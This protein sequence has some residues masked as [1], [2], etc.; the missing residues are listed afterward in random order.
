VACETV[1]RTSRGTEITVRNGGLQDTRFHR[2]DV[3]TRRVRFCGGNTV[4]I[5]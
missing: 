2:A 1:I 3:F 4:F 5:Y